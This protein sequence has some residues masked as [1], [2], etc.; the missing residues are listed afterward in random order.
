MEAEPETKVVE[1]DSKVTGE[2]PAADALDHGA[3]IGRYQLIQRLGHGGM[4]TVYLG[5]A[6]GKGGFEKLVAIKAIHA[7]LANE[8]DFLEM[9]LDEARIAA[10]IHHPHV[11]E[12]LDLGEADGLSFMVMEYVEGE[13]LSGLIR[14][15]RK[16]EELLPVPV[17]V[18]IVTDAC[19]GIG[20]AHQLEDRDG[21]SYN[22]V[23]RDVSPQNLLV[24]LDGW[25]KVVDFGIMKASGKRSNTL[26][27]QLRGKL[28]Y[29][30][31]EQA[32]G[33]SLDHR[34]DLFAMGVVL[35]E[36]L[37]NE[38]VF[39]GGSEAKTIDNVATGNIPEIQARRPD[40]PVALCDIVRRSL[41]AKIE[42][43]YAT[44]DAMARDL[45]GVL[46]SC[47]GDEDPR[48]QL[49]TIMKSHFG[50]RFE[51]AR[52]VVRAGGSASPVPAPAQESPGHPDESNRMA[53]VPASTGSGSSRS[54][55]EMHTLTSSLAG[56][57][58]RHWSLWLLLPLIGAAIGTGVVTWRDEP[59]LNLPTEMP[60]PAEV[61][62]Q[63]A[64]V[65]PDLQSTVKWLF[66]TEPQG[67]RVYI[68]GKPQR[69]ATPVEI[70]VPRGEKAL[71]VRIELS[72]HMVR[73]VRL[74][75]VE[76]DNYNFSLAPLSVTDDL[77]ALRVGPLR[78][79]APPKPDKTRRRTSTGNPDP[80]SNDD[81]GERT[82]DPM[83]DFKS[84]TGG[85]S[86][87]RDG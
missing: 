1:H 65:A 80:V 79:S 18:Q 68:E 77:K 32:R 11:V 25:V 26:T 75:P 78:L 57:P 61:E 3:S 56:A 9:F 64:A 82:L 49:A 12:I 47:S 2:L 6:A 53:G 21:K 70:A 87:A 41:S 5:R 73:E 38:R 83:P 44:A 36:L 63:S 8:P 76:S 58:A 48:R 20:A 42:H 40:L 86:T 17:V 39:Q 15:L 34:T 67:A 24:G 45:K 50:A 4:A 43:R 37:T 22:L 74:A 62:T 59:T 13:T 7:H 51:Y 16:R 72:G 10:R 66:N 52:A 14:V 46:R 29:M 23:H 84:Q 81:N 60:R 85:K 55:M 54:S 69:G 27:G 35:W 30:S 28:P 71:N 31:P 33:E 19:E